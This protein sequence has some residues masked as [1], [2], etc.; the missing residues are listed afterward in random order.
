[1][2]RP[3][4]NTIPSPHIQHDTKKPPIMRNSPAPPGSIKH[5][6]IAY[7]SACLHE[8]Y[9][10]VPN[11]FTGVTKT[12]QSGH[13]TMHLQHGTAHGDK[14]STAP[15]RDMFVHSATIIASTDDDHKAGV[16]PSLCSLH[17]LAETDNQ[18][19]VQHTAIPSTIGTELRNH[20]YSYF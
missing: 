6:N 16:I 18:R 14:H 20:R 8:R 17:P 19:P 4:S 11:H 3:R 12:T 5:N 1:M 9:R 13:T 7:R 10:P 15:A 2:Q